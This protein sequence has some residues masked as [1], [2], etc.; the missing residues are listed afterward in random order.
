[1]T[2]LEHTV[3]SIREQGGTAIAVPTDVTSWDSVRGMAAEVLERLGGIDLLFNNA[4]RFHSVGPLWEADPNDWWEDVTVNLRGV[5]L[6]CRAV[7]PHM[8]SRR[9]GAI[10]NMDGGGGSVGPNIGGSGYG[11]SKAAVVRF[12][13][14]LARELERENLDILVFCMNPGFVLTDMTRYLVSHPDLLKWQPHVPALVGSPKQLPVDACA[15]AAVRLLEIASPELSGR[16]F[17]ADADFS[18][19]H[20][21]RTRIRRENLFVLCYE[22]GGVEPDRSI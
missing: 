21:E 12:S 3:E 17:Y 16:I 14:G 11:C 2:D 8:I 5:M 9:A 20:R 10:I 18:A 13:E 22:T 15:R 4:G 7:L 19:V 6:C 1:M